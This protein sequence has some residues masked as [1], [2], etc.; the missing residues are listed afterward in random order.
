MD[1]YLYNKL[2]I[3]IDVYFFRINLKFFKENFNKIIIKK[4][5]KKKSIISKQYHSIFFFFLRES[6][7]WGVE[8]GKGERENLKQAP[9][10]AQI[11]TQ[12]RSHNPEI[13]T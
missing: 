5:L 10:P 13:M 3:Y 12:A 2:Y 11:L 6:M 8:V 7:R 9:H 4:N 1:K